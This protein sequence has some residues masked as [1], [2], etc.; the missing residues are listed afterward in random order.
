MKQTEMSQFN[1]EEKTTDEY[2]FTFSEVRDLIHTIESFFNEDSKQIEK[3]KF[4][5]QLLEKIIENYYIKK[6]K[7]RSNINS[8]NSLT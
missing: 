7:N 1:L 5:L 4:F 2:C 6:D 8:Y 3:R